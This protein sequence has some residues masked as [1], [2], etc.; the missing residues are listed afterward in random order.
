MPRSERRDYEL[1]NSRERKRDSETKS[2]DDDD[3]DV[4]ITYIPKRVRETQ[5]QARIAQF[6]SQQSVSAATQARLR[7]EE[8]E[9]RRREEEEAKLLN[10]D[11][12]KTLVEINQEILQER[13]G[14]AKTEEELL[15]EEEAQL[16]RHLTKDRA[17]LLGR[18][19][20]AGAVERQQERMKTSWRPARSVRKMTEE[21]ARKIREKYRI[22]VDGVDIPPPIKKFA[23][24]SLPD[25]ILDAL[26]DRGIVAPTPIQ[27]QGLPVALSGRDM[28]GI[29]FTGSGKTLVFTLPMIMFALEAEVMNPLRRG[30]GPVGFCLVPSRELA[31][32]IHGIAK[33]FAT[34]LARDKF[35]QLNILLAIG[36]VDMGEQF[37]A[38][39]RESGVHV[40][41]ATP[42]RI[43]DLLTK[44]RI[45]FNRCI[46]MAMDEADRLIDLTFESE[47]RTILDHFTGPRQT[48]LFSATMPKK[49]QEF[50]LSALVDP[51][52]VNVGRAGAANLDVIQEV[53]YVKP[54]AK[55]RYLLECLQ[56]TAP[57]VLIFAANQTAV[58]DIQEYLMLHNV[59]V[60]A[61][62]G[63]MDQRDRLQAIEDFKNGR[64]DVLVATDVASKGLDFADIQHVIN[65]D[66]PKEIEDY[67]HRIGR[68][69]RNGKTGVATSFV[70]RDC[71]ETFLLD[72]K[73]LLKEAN[74]KIPPV[75]QALDDG[76]TS[77]S[78]A[79]DGI[80]G[81]AYCGGLGHRVMT[82]PKLRQV[83]ASKLKSSSYDRIE[84]NM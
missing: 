53:E 37:R 40:V 45:N 64:K 59:D 60:C 84:S 73:H 9:R 2:V 11:E 67:V 48:V 38:I 74:Q 51:I 42:G 56:K 82:C 1:S 47:V 20:A 4:E 79:V 78:I 24:M 29:A 62:H 15:A 32:Q 50:A 6:Q 7:R 81:C 23:L 44:K 66:M 58:D 77:N 13:G 25:A 36:G 75:L 35:P 22:A 76:S 49:I 57:P 10:P 41:I 69:G 46:Y 16:L 68:T 30:E 19:Q 63:G 12:G 39:P 72:L 65:Y 14:Q 83:N 26:Q 5:A 3:E 43:V 21:E 31:G 18:K 55:I 27:I 61:V 54:E 28:I 8:E 33:H 17:P 52:V 70:N 71:S 80:N 34:Y